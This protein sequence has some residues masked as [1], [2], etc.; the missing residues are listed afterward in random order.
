ML[1]RRKFSAEEKQKLLPWLHGGNGNVIKMA[2]YL[3]L[4]AHVYF[5]V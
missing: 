1:E 5:F 3:E 4:T 2:A